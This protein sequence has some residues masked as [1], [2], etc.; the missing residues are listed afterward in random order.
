MDSALG[1]PWYSN[2]LLVILVP[3]RKFEIAMQVKTS[4]DSHFLTLPLGWG[5]G[6]GVFAVEFTELKYVLELH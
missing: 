4:S 2:L 5:G 1:K 3:F 6:N